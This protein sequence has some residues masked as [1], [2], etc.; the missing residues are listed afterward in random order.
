M[1]VIPEDFRRMVN[2]LEETHY[3]I[4]LPVVMNRQIMYQISSLFHMNKNQWRTINLSVLLNVEFHTDNLRV[5]HQAWVETALAVGDDLDES[6][7]QNLY[8]TQLKK[9]TLMKNA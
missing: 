5:F 1:K 4:K 2:V 3:K 8:E 7:T 9:S 6:A